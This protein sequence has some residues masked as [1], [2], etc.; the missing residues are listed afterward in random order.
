MGAI[1]LERRAFHEAGHAVAAVLL[2]RRFKKVSIIRGGSGSYGRTELHERRWEA[3]APQTVEREIIITL[4]GPVAERMVT[5]RD[6]TTPFIEW[7]GA[8]GDINRAMALADFAVGIKDK[9]AYLRPL[10][11]R[12][13][14]LVVGEGREAVMVLAA[15]LL[16]ARQMPEWGGALLSWRRWLRV[17]SRIRGG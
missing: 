10:M 8:S 7:R 2:R 3:P 5:A 16:A 9:I 13:Q 14:R 11:Y 17:P 15:E 6:L 12:A 4:S 1:T